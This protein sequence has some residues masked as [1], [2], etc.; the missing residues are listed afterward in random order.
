MS[1]TRR[2]DARESDAGLKDRVGSSTTPDML[3]PQL[4]D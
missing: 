2:R 3:A 4:L 1:S